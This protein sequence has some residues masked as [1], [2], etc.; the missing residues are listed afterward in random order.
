[1][2]GWGSALERADCWNHTWGRKVTLGLAV[3]DRCYRG[4]GT[5]AAGVFPGSRN[6]GRCIQSSFLKSEQGMW[7]LCLARRSLFWTRYPTLGWRLPC[8]AGVV[9]PFHQFSQ[10]SRGVWRTWLALWTTILPPAELS[11]VTGLPYCIPPIFPSHVEWHPF[12]VC[13]SFRIHC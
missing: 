11:S 5:A 13:W 1:M 7:R 12:L 2:R 8:L 4:G 3:I 10:A 9:S 6:W